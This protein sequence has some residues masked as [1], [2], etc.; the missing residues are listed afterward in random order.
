MIS[1]YKFK[2]RNGGQNVIE[3]GTVC[4]SL[5]PYSKSSD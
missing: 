4:I 5:L 2:K 3:W 1:K